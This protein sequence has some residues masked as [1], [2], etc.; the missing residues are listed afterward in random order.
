[1]LSL[2]TSTVSTHFN[3][4]YTTELVHHEG[5]WR[6]HDDVEWA[7]LTYVHWFNHTRLHSE[8]GMQP[9]AENEH[10]RCSQ[11]IP[12]ET[13]GTQPKS[14][15]K[16]RGYS[17]LGGCCLATNSDVPAAQLDPAEEILTPP[18]CMHPPLGRTVIAFVRLGAQQLLPAQ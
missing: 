16:T 3:G 18:P 14:P 4:L 13:A 9:P 1:M 12:V 11:T 6:G 2:N 5:P 10:A 8:I 15:Y 7:T 17:V